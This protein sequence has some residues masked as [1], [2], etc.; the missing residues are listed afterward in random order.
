MFGLCQLKRTFSTRCS[1]SDWSQ[2]SISRGRL[3]R[4]YP[5]RLARG[6]RR[7]F[8]GAEFPDCSCRFLFWRFM[9]FKYWSQSLRLAG[10]GQRASPNRSRR[11]YGFLATGEQF[12][13]DV[14]ELIMQETNH[15]A[16]LAGH[17]GVDGVA[18]EQVAEDG[19]F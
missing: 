1:R 3:D 2:S 7:L 6:S 11:V 5:D 13:G 10:G 4:A 8:E 9:A 15:Q 18:R 12:D 16:S 14:N 17:G 19:I